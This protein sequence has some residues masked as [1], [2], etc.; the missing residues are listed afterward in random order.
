M[1]NF[2]QKETI[3]EEKGDMSEFEKYGFNEVYNFN[4]NDEYE[5]SADMVILVWNKNQV[6]PAEQY[7]KAH[8]EG[9]EVDIAICED[10]KIQKKQIGDKAIIY[11]FVGSSS[12][13][14]N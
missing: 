4:T 12:G 9:K 14:G 13:G 7:R 11:N 5:G 2:N 10:P 8:Y 6:L 3:K 1:E